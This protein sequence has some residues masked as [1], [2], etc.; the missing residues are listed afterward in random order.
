MYIYFC[1]TGKEFDYVILCTVR[2]VANPSIERYP[3]KKWK[4]SKLGQLV[5]KAIVTTALTRAK[6]GLIIVG[7]SYTVCFTVRILIHVL[8][9]FFV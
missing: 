4:L 8:F 5:D 6:K 7:K 9:S 2:T 3:D 1:I